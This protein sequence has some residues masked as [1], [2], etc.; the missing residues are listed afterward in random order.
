VLGSGNNNNHDNISLSAINLDNRAKLALNSARPTSKAKLFTL[1]ELNLSN[2]AISKTAFKSNIW[3]QDILDAALSVIS[4]IADRHIVQN[5]FRVSSVSGHT[6]STTKFTRINSNLV[7][8]SKGT[9]ELI[10][11]SVLLAINGLSMIVDSHQV[12]KFF[13]DLPKQHPVEV[14]LFKFPQSDY[15]VQV[16]IM[17][18]KQVV[19]LAPQCV[20]NQR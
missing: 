13:P 7:L 14:K 6:F 19:C 8:T 15:Q 2:N 9:T 5:L 11:G 18:Q 20:K 16:C 10:E 4:M 17:Q 1:E 3:S 12:V